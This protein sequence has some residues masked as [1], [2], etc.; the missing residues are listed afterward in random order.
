MRAFDKVDWSQ[1]PT[2]QLILM[3]VPS[4]GDPAMLMRVADFLDV[5]ALYYPATARWVGM[6]PDAGL[7]FGTA[8]LRLVDGV[9]FCREDLAA[10][11]GQGEIRLSP[12]VLS[13]E[14][15]R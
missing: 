4:L 3:T 8:P 1:V 6:S 7:R 15:I 12:A 11:D 2:G 14:V 10:Q 9:W 5:Q 13:L